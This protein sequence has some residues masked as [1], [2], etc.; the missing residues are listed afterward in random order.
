MIYSEAT[1]YV[2]GFARETEKCTCGHIDVLFVHENKSQKWNLALDD[3][4]ARVLPRRLPLAALKVIGIIGQGR[5][6]VIHLG[7]WSEIPILVALITAWLLQIPVTVDSDT[8]LVRRVAGWK[9]FL[10]RALY[11]L[12]LRIPK[13]LL[14]CGT[15]QAAYF[16]N[17]GVKTKR[18]TILPMTV[19]VNYIG[20]RCS[21]LGPSG[22]VAIR[23]RLGFSADDLVYI[24][25]GRLFDYKGILDLLDAFERLSA[26]LQKTRLLIV[27]DGVERQ[28]VEDAAGKNHSMKYAG[29]LDREGLFEMYH[30]SDLLV[31]PSHREQ[32]GLVV[33][34]GMAAG[35]PVIATDSV[36]CVGDL[37]MNDVTG[38]VIKTGNISDLV[39]AMTFIAINQ[40]ERER[41]GKMADSIISDWTLEKSAKIIADV[42]MRVGKL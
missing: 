9:R 4:N 15:K 29:Q 24:Y 41:L 16:H 12:L 7:G 42:W 20:K 31:V 36:G 28:S 21:E 38:K 23:K 30:A 1:P 33:N 8:H 37:V 14:P 32:W 22:R 10:K 6:N 18:I 40:S 3:L 25:V 5:Y 27:G 2:L 13:M 26:I 17:Y 34:E 35:L 19:D 11:P 39:D